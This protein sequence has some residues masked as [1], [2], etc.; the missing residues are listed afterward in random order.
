MKIFNVTLRHAINYQTSSGQ[1]KYIHEGTQIQVCR[2]APGTVYSDG[3]RF[4]G[5]VGENS[6]VGFY[7]TDSMDLGSED[8][9]TVD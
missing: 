1:V 6:Y 9:K 3:R 5:V 7:G 8:F 2:I 4:K